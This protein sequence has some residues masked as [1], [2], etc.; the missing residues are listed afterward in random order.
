MIKYVLLLIMLQNFLK[1]CEYTSK[2]F[3]LKYDNYL[4]LKKII[5]KN[6]SSFRL[7]NYSLYKIDIFI[8]ILKK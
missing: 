1:F 7:Y 3:H 4:S 5:A 6:N 2:N 8:V